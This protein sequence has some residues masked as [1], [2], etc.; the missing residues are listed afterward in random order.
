MSLP[1]RAAIIVAAAV[2]LPAIGACSSHPTRV[3]FWPLYFHEKIGD[4]ETTE[5]L[6]PFGG[7]TKE[8]T[9]S[10]AGVW[11][12]VTVRKDHAPIAPHEVSWHS[13]FP[14]FVDRKDRYSHKT[15]LLPLYMR[16]NK[17]LADGQRKIDNVVFPLVWWG[18]NPPEKKYFAFFPFY[19]SIRSRLARDKI[20]FVLWPIYS[21]SELHGHVAKGVLW[22]LI[23]WTYGG[24]RRSSRVLP[25]YTFF[26][27]DGEPELW[28]VLWPIIHFSKSTGEEQ[29][30]RS[31]FYIFPLFGWDNTFRQHK[32]VVLWPFFTYMTKPGTDYYRWVGP[33]PILR[34]QKDKDLT[35][36]Q[37]W[38]FYGYLKQ[39]E[40]IIR[41]ILWPLYRQFDKDTEKLRQKEWFIL[42][43]IQNKVVYDKVQKRTH[44]RR[45][46]W[47]LFRY[48]NKGDSTKQFVAFSPLWYWNERGF[49]RNYSRFWR[50]FEYVKNTETDETSWRVIW[51]LIRYD[52]F[53]NYR[54][55]NFLGPLFR[56]E[57][58]PDVQ[59]RFTILGGLLSVGSRGGKPVFK[60]LYIPFASGADPEKAEASAR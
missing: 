56:Y 39:D 7:S 28:S 22:P 40:N 47:P 2:V 49:E 34:F 15:W 53:R 14:F 59:R 35:R 52:R 25:F 57:Y 4:R 50:V 33:W 21:R 24:N 42:Y 27:K 26:Q 46:F 18:R 9:F 3:D 60:L 54:T 1:R 48:F 44:V 13:I 12:L 29:I 36:R 51:R 23:A 32:T 37:V 41:Y 5:I 20:S 19:G 43:I 38:P 10:E 58:E 11:P 17:L 8:P 6:W 31:L 45:M 30:P 55:F 16:T